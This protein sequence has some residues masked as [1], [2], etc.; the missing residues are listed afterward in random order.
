ML[1]RGRRRGLGGA[2]T[3]V[4]DRL[5]YVGLNK[6]PAQTS[7]AHFFTVDNTLVYW[8]FFLDFGACAD[9]PLCGGLAPRDS[10]PNAYHDAI[11]LCL[12]LR[13]QGRSRWVSSTS[14]AKSST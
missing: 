13:A 3:I 7:D 2:A 14:S 12:F 10:N 6:V 1:P 9:P 5:F 4:E 8:N 11:S